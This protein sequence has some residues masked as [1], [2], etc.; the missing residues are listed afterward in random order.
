M[1]HRGA[2]TLPGQAGPVRDLYATR[3]NRNP[4]GVGGLCG[5]V[6]PLAGPAPPVLRRGMGDQFHPAVVAPFC[7][8][9]RVAN[10]S[11]RKEAP[12]PRIDVII[13]KIAVA[14]VLLLMTAVQGK[15]VTF[16][17]RPFFFVEPVTSCPNNVFG[18]TLSPPIPTPDGFQVT[19]R[20]VINTLP[21]SPIAAKL[22]FSRQ[23]YE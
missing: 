20:L 13:L 12:M 2:G 4:R 19:G 7:R 11:S 1:P 14:M 6:R 16:G 15:A 8:P 22:I 5:G 17:G 23:G 18:H 9:M 3:V 10:N 21:L